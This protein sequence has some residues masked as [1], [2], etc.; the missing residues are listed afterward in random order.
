[1]K[2]RWKTNPETRQWEAVWSLLLGELFQ[3]R[4]LEAFAC[5]KH[6]KC[7]PQ[8]HTYGI[9]SVA[10]KA[11]SYQN[12]IDFFQRNLKTSLMEHCKQYQKPTLF[13]TSWLRTLGHSI[14]NQLNFH[15]Y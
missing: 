11:W 6:F 9:A 4:A 12:G 10:K 15:A 3:S 13:S 1:M 8:V 7:F 14:A 2:K 5:Q